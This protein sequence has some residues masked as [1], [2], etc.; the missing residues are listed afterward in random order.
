MDAQTIL[1]VWLLV[2]WPIG[3]YR[4]IKLAGLEGKPDCQKIGEQILYESVYQSAAVIGTNIKFV[5]M[6]ACLYFGGFYN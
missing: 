3:I 1:T 4:N 2:Q 6:F 5:G